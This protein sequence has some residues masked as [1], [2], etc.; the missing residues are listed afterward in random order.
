MEKLSA[1]AA[2]VLRIAMN[3]L[4]RIAGATSQILLIFVFTVLMVSSRR[5]LRR[6][7]ERI[8]AMS[9]LSRPD[10]VL[11]E[12]T[13]L[14]GRF[15]LARF[16]IVLIVGAV[17]VV[18]LKLFGIPYYILLG[19]FLGLLT[20]L[21]AIGFI[22]AVIPPVIVSLAS[23]HGLLNTVL[24]VL[25]LAGMSCADTYFLTPKMVG[26]RLN[27]SSLASFVGIFAGGLLW[28]ISGMLLS[29][30]ILGVMRVVFG[31]TPGLEPWG[32]LLMDKDLNGEKSKEH[33]ESSGTRPKTPHAA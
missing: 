10:V 20:L 30:P 11:N 17:D 25:P 32:D 14:I 7:G 13:S 6:A 33:R 8:L 12:S 1:S 28:G 4:G 5:H 29:I 2:D 27:I 26:N 9:S 19:G 3:S 31:A 23:G 21:P 16:A 15:L 18:V 22:L 24:M